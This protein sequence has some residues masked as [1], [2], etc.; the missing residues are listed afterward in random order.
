MKKVMIIAAIAAAALAF[1]GE[2][3]T[4][5]VSGDYA[6]LAAGE[7]VYAGN[8]AAVGTNGCA[9][10][11]NT[12]AVGG[13]LTVCGVF[14]NSAAAGENVTVKRGGFILE[15]AG[16][17]TKA[18]I[19]ATVYSVSANAWTVTKTNGTKTV[20]K[21]ADVRDDGSVVVVVGR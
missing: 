18:E 3:D 10:A 1:A 5:Q 21:V 8:I 6:Q 14:L 11:V 4:P 2:H 17:V 20:G 19:G 15:N 16:N 13:T 9:Y 12:S 7:A